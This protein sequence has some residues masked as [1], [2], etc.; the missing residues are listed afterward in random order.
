MVLYL[1]DLNLYPPHRTRLLR[2]LEAAVEPWRAMDASF[3][4]ARFENRLEVLVPPTGDLDVILEGAASWPKGLARAVQ[5]RT[6]R[7]LA[8][9]QMLSSNEA[10]QQPCVDNWGHLVSIGRAYANE[11]ATRAAIAAD[12]LADLVTT[13]AGVPGKK[14]VVHVTD[15]LPQRPGI[16]MFDYLGNQLCL[17]RRTT[18]PADVMAEMLEH[19]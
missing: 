18:A 6:A 12:G 4:L 10:S 8:I 7:R 3:M 14:A 5:H 11:E 15:G 1:D 17:G 2:R 9:G 13:L 16:A 19:D